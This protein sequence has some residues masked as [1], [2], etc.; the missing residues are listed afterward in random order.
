MDPDLILDLR[1]RAALSPQS[2]F[3]REG[4]VRDRYEERAVFKAQHRQWGV[5]S[6]G[7][8]CVCVCVDRSMNQYGLLTLNGTF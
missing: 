4:A 6:R 7:T 3:D 2:V 5:F 8:R 1:Q